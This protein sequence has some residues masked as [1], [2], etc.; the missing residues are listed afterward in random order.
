MLANKEA[1]L[2]LT[3]M[4]QSEIKELVDLEGQMAFVQELRNKLLGRTISASG[5][6]IVDNQGA[7]ILADSVSLIEEDAVLLATEVRTRWGVI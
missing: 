3:G 4:E 2:T 1:S 7:M 5:R 6:S